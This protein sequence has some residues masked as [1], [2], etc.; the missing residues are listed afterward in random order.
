[1]KFKSIF[2]KST[3]IATGVVLA[4]STLTVAAATNTKKP[5]TGVKNVIMIVADGTGMPYYSAYRYLNDNPTKPGLDTTVFDTNMTGVQTVFSTF[6]GENIPDSAATATSMATGFKTKNNVIG[7]DENMNKLKTVLE[8]AKEDGLSTG[9]VATSEITHATPASYAAHREHRSM[10]DQIADDFYDLKINGKHSVDV[11]LG[12]GLKNFERKDRNLVEAFKKDGYGIAKTK[13]ELLSNKNS[14]V[15]GLFA[16]GGFAPAID[17]TSEVPSLLE[18]SKSAV[19]RLS[20]NDKG[21]FLM[22]EASQID[23]AGHNNDIVYAMSEMK[24]YADV[25][26]FATEWAKKNGETQVIATADHN[27]GGMS[28]GVGGIYKWN[29]E[30]IKATTRTPQFMSQEIAAGGD[31]EKTL[32]SYVKFPLSVD[33][34]ATVKKAVEDAKGDAKKVES[35]TYVAIK[36]IFDNRTFT[37]WTTSGHTGDEVPVMAY[38]KLSQKLTGIIDNT[39]H[40]KVIFENLAKNKAAK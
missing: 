7:L 20:K 23:W 3:V 39:Q 27:T 10:M 11:L 36:K 34:I 1:M 32:A 5:A 38:G 16:N 9:L 13:A 19:E 12:G 15:L 6:T 30:P 18:M 37:G 40:A 24:E 31:V 21:F 35:G 28:L 33:E 17:R 2:R 26:K 22:I 25:F 8:Q 14:Q 4:A 29:A